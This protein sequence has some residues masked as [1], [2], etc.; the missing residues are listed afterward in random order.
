MSANVTAEDV[1]KYFQGVCL[2]CCTEG[3]TRERI[4]RDIQL[5]E[6]YFEYFSVNVFCNNTTSIKRDTALVE[7]FIHDLYPTIKENPHLE[8][9]LDNTD[10]GVG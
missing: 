7:W 5:A 8:I 9:L 2:L 4:I 1:A 3:E 10:L 6:Q